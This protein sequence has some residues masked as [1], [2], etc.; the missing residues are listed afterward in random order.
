MAFYA[1]ERSH[2]AEDLYKSNESDAG[3]YGSIPSFNPYPREYNGLGQQSIEANIMND[4]ESKSKPQSDERY[5]AKNG[6]ENS[7]RNTSNTSHPSYD[8]TSLRSLKLAAPISSQISMLFSY[9]TYAFVNIIVSVPSLYGY[10]AVIFNNNAFNDHMNALSKL[11]I[12]SSCVHQLAF[13]LFSTLP[14][15]IGT[16]QDAGL[17][18]LSA[19]A[20]IIANTILEDGGTIEEIISTTCVLLPL[21]TALL[22]LVL[23]FMGKYK[24][25]DGTNCFPMYA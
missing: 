16:V 10:A 4:E 13:A 20:N 15:A 7:Q 19:M 11:V 6:Q 3:G 18:F 1:N 25:A 12:L 23:V 14:F 8:D 22:G 5:T 2:S 24:L 9:L 21:G 17:L